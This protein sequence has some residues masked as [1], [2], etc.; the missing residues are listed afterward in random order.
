MLS[1][2]SSRTLEIAVGLVD[3]PRHDR[4]RV[5]PTRAAEPGLAV[6]HHVGHDRRHAERRVLIERQVA[7]PAPPEGLRIEQRRCGGR[8]RLG[9]ARPAQSLVA[10]R[11]VCRHGH[12]VVALRPHHVLVE[13]YERGLGATEVPAARRVAADRHQLRVEQLGARLDLGVPE[14][15]E[16]ERRLER[17]RSGR[18]RARRCRSPWPIGAPACG[19]SHPARAPRHAAR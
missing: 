9:V 17:D 7:E 12:E 18:R 8:E 10:L 3:R 15:V 4:R 6:D 1:R 14:A 19:A 2:W 13:A 16:G 11:T 5:G